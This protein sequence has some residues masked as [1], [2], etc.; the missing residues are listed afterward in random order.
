MSRDP[1]KLGGAG[2]VTVTAVQ[3]FENGLFFNIFE[4]VAL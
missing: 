2:L 3:R 1:E 4:V